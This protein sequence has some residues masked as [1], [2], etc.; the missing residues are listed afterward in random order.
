MKSAAIISKPGKTELGQI[1]PELLSWFRQRGYQL[2]M[3]EETARYTMAS[4]Q[5]R[6]DRAEAPDLRWC[7]EAMA[8]CCRQRAPWPMRACLS[9]R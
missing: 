8:P 2:Y 7:W 5:S 4:R 9:W 6:G 3:D 1:L